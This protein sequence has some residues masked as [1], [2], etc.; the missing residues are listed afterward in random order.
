MT[1]AMTPREDTT[2]RPS[3]MLVERT[4]RTWLRATKI[5]RVGLIVLCL[6]VLVASAAVASGASPAPSSDGTS[7]A[8]AAEPAPGNTGPSRSG[9]GGGFGHVGF[10]GAGQVAGG[11]GIG[12]AITIA[13]VEGSDV[14]LKTDDGWTRTITVTDQTEIRI[15]NQKVSLSD[16]KV[17]DD[18]NLR[19]TKNS[20]G[21]YIVTLIVVRVPTVAGTITEITTGGFTIK[22][23]S[24]ST[25]IVTVSGST[26][27]LIAGST[28]AESDLSVGTKVQVEGTASSGDT[29]AARVVHIVPDVRIG[30]VTA[31]ASTTITIKSRDG[32]TPTI[33][34]DAKT[35]YRVA[36]TASATITD[37][38]VGMLITA[39][40]TSR[41]DGSL[42]ALSVFAG[43]FKMHPKDL[44]GKVHPIPPSS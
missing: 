22:Q 33:H 3:T 18:V 12:R 7:V 4:G 21:T 25:K 42:D 28:G 34:V 38:K 6:V 16:L 15:G 9:N 11:P 1:N 8:P 30:T 40:G 10:F 35:T 23:R 5:A 26:D 39:V 41:S 44:T 2:A 19:E 17:G 36:G 14:S 20:N 24:G 27:Y 29:F 32:S 31:T 13:K 43:Q 37:V